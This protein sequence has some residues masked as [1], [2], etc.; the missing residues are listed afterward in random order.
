MTE[1]RRANAEQAEAWSGDDGRHWAAYADAHDEMS[2]QFSDA[3]LSAADVDGGASV[4]DVGCGCGATT[5]E[6]ASRASGGRAVGID[7]SGPMLDVA[8]RRADER[9]VANVTFV[10]GDAQTHR[11]EPESVDVVLS[12]FGVMFFDDPVAAF[13]NMRAAVRPSGRLAFVCWR[14]MLANEWIM[15]PGAAVAAHVGLPDMG[16]P[17]G[18]GP[19][20]FAD[21][22]RIED[23]LSHARWTSITVDPLERVLLMPG[24]G[25]DGT[26]RYMLDMPMVRR[27]LRGASQDAA[28]RATA[29]LRDALEQHA[30][31]D[32]VRLRGAAWLVRA[33]SG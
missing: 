4:L 14:D 17:G 7:L 20:A 28:D 9:G 12:R 11:F 23:V 31:P 24:R 26:V 1:A 19:F 10:Q 8:R 16:E 27:M 30:G 2:R 3:L 22:A 29:A 13:T 25:A 18:P 5:L 15:V 32:G 6:A 21:R 33:T